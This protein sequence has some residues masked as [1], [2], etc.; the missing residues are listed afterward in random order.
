MKKRNLLL[1]LPFLLLVAG[2][3]YPITNQV[4]RIG[5]A[6][7]PTGV[8]PITNKLGTNEAPISVTTDAKIII[9]NGSRLSYFFQSTADF[10]VAYGSANDVVPAAPP[11]GNGST[12]C[13]A[14]ALLKANVPYAENNWPTNRLDAACVT[15]T[16]LI[17]TIECNP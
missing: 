10:C 14:G 5:A 11:I 16:C 12:S 3:P 6:N 2:Q 15:G 4:Q 17:S 13:T 8:I 1:P 9:G 7:C